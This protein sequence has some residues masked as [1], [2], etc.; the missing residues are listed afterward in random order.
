M[1][2]IAR[3]RY[4]ADEQR[5]VAGSADRFLEFWTLKEAYLKALGVGLAGGLDSLECTGLSRSLGDWME[6]GAH[7]GW[8]FRQL[9]PRP[10]VV[11]ALAVEGSPE[12]VELRRW[13][14]D[15]GGDGASAG[16]GT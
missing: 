6:S 14:P 16:P 8:R 9:Q 2:G 7:P 13:A 10:G 4:S 11:A 12:R 15:A 3:R 1:G 5:A